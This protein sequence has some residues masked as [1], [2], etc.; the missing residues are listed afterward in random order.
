M[1]KANVTLVTICFYMALACQMAAA[2]T[3]FK[4]G[5]TDLAPF[6]FEKNGVVQGISTDILIILWEK[7]EP[8]LLTQGSRVC[9]LPSACCI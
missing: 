3:K 2:Q 9:R 7:S 4:I 1:K 5:T 6:S 8:L